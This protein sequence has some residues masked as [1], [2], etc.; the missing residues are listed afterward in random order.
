VRDA[1]AVV[2]PASVAARFLPRSSFDAVAADAA[3]RDPAREEVRTVALREDLSPRRIAE[4]VDD[5]LPLLAVEDRLPI[6]D[7]LTPSSRSTSPWYWTIPAMRGAMRASFSDRGRQSLPRVVL[8]PRAFKSLTMPRRLSLW[9]MLAA[10]ERSSSAPRL[11]RV[12]QSSFQP[13]G[14]TVRPVSGLRP[15]R[16]RS[17]PLS[18]RCRACRA[19]RIEMFSDSR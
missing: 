19:T 5:E 15:L 6:A 3:E 11:F 12:R 16:T 13:N 8:M 10:A 14:R 4:L 2:A 7:D 17:A 18:A 1:A 9:R